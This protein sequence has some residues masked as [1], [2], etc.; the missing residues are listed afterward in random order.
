MRDYPFYKDKIGEVIGKL[1][2]ECQKD[3]KKQDKKE[4]Y[5]LYKDLEF[6]CQYGYLFDAKFKDYYKQYTEY[7]KEVALKRVTEDKNRAKI[8]RELYWEVVKIESF[9]F[10]ESYLIYMEHKREYS[11][12]FYEPRRKTQHIAVEDLQA[13][14]DS[15]TMK[16]YTLSEPPRIG[17]STTILFFLSWNILRHPHSH[18]A[19]G[20]YSGPVA[21][22]FYEEFLK[23]LTSE[24]Y[25]FQEL[26]AFFQ[27]KEKFITNKSAEQMQI[28]FNDESFAT[29]SFRGVDGSWTGLVDVSDDGYLAVD[30]L[31]RDKEHAMSKERT[32]KTY[33]AYVNTM[34]DRLHE[35]SKQ[36]LIGTLWYLYDPIMRI[37]DKH[38]D[39]PNY[40][41]RKI[42]ALNENDESNFDYEYEGYSTEYYKNMRNNMIEDGLESDWMAK[43]QQSPFN[44]E[45]Q[46]YPLEELGYFN[47]IL[48]VGHKYRFV[49]N[50]DVAFGGG[51]SV[52][53]PIGIHDKTENI[54]YIVDWYFNSSGVLVTVPGVVDMI[55]KHG[56]KS[57]D[58]EAN[59][60]GDLYASKIQEELSTRNYLCACN[61]VRASNKSS[62]EDKILSCEGTVRKRFRFLSRITP[63]P[64]EV[65]EDTI[66]YKRTPQYDRAL[67]ELS[68][69][70]TRGKNNHDDAVDSISQIAE[71]VFDTMQ[72]KTVI[73][74]CPF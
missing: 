21:K 58:F 67:N 43:F 9:S 12:R 29:I 51:D 33:E 1:R 62:K 39:D 4:I 55:I 5:E 22:H 3:E 19:M 73:M 70:S 71:R 24:E 14:E 45:G 60:G 72:R 64:E 57:I 6:C 63:N 11:K 41:F 50:C 53:M 74:D 66:I 44:R 68:S 35:H 37:M 30:D 25:C 47:G 2:I 48:P 10:F 38:K 40:V 32:D 16:V 18:N 7:I 56:I 8:W 65:D 13:L 34:M 28:F 17:K 42:P 36:L 46:L 61:S 27:P 15:K 69:Y 52:S 20:T 23:I 31:I 59:A 26:Y 54:I 49:V